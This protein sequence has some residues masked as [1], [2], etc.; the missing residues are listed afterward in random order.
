[1]RSISTG[2]HLRHADINRNGE[3][4]KTMWRAA[5]AMRGFFNATR[6]A[7]SLLKPSMSRLWVAGEGIFAKT[8]KMDCALKVGRFMIA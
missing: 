1:M 3:W 2:Q 7:T 4:G 6:H 5:N 8:A